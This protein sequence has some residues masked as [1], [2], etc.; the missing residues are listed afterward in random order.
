MSGYCDL[1]GHTICI[2]AD[3]RKR[4]T[5][6][7]DLLVRAADQLEQYGVHGDLVEEIDKACGNV[8]TQK[9]GE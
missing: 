3:I 8:L 6:Y 4:V 2:C 5:A 7:E 1:C 9:G